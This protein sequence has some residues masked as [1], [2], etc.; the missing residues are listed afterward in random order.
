MPDRPPLPEPFRCDVVPEPGAARVVL[1]G[2]LD[3]ATGQI[4]ERTVE[5]LVAAGTERVTV[6]LRRLAFMDSSGLRLLLRWDERARRQGTELLLI[7]G[8]PAVQRV[9][10]TTRLLERLHFVDPPP[11]G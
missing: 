7:A 4:L 2:E 3:M 1:V 5:E 8:P 6:D 10:E 9:F 11:D